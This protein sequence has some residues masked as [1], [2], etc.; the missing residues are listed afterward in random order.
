MQEFHVKAKVGDDGTI[1]VAGLPLQPGQEVEVTIEAGRP[2][3]DNSNPYPLR[4]TVR[5]YTGPFESV[6]EDD[7]EVLK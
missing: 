1:T 3:R 2:A 7:W 6:A 5:S 4:G